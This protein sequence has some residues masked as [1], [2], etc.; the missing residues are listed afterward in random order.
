[1]V[2]AAIERAWNVDNDKD[3]ERNAPERISHCAFISE[4]VDVPRRGTGGHT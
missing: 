4:I 3:A 2:K 1:M